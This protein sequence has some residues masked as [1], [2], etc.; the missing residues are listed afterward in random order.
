M[1]LMYLHL[2]DSRCWNIPLIIVNRQISRLQ[3]YYR[4]LLES[5]ERAKNRSDS[6]FGLNSFLIILHKLSNM[7]NY[8]HYSEMTDKI[9]FKNIFH[10]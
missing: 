3:S 8:N 6:F 9:G 4:F 10:I 2:V 7:V 5:S 1:K